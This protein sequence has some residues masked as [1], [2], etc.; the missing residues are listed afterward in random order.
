MQ[1][2]PPFKGMDCYADDR[3]A[4]NDFA[5]YYNNAHLSDLTMVVG[6]E[7][8]VFSFLPTIKFFKDIQHTD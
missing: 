1:T 6:E 2:T 7:M 4:L 3:D 5:K 8:F